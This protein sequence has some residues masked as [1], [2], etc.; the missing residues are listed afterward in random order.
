MANKITSDPAQPA[1]PAS[2]TSIFNQL[3]P[4]AVSED[5][6][7]LS[8][9][10]EETEYEEPALMLVELTKQFNLYHPGT[11]SYHFAM[12]RSAARGV[13]EQQTRRTLQLESAGAR[14]LKV[15]RKA[16]QE[17]EMNE[18]YDT[19]IETEDLYHDRDYTRGRLQ[20][21]A[22][23]LLR[24]LVRDSA[25]DYTSEFPDQETTSRYL[26]IL[27]A[28]EIDAYSKYR[29]AHEEV[30]LHE[31]HEEGTA[32]HEALAAPRGKDGHRLPKGKK[33]PQIYDSIEAWRDSMGEH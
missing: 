8:A 6:R 28:D 11:R 15:L 14:F 20:D 9:L 31:A 17:A 22:Q 21:I 10:L 19:A 3:P 2:Q 26:K 33:E 30:S 32:M 24:F 4:H 1:Q 23:L 25:M 27:D 13:V 7:H 12:F 29:I 18:N 16:F 5:D